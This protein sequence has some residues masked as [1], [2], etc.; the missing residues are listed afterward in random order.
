MSFFFATYTDVIPWLDQRDDHDGIHLAMDLG[1][2]VELGGVADALAV[3]DGIVGV[4]EIFAATPLSWCVRRQTRR[5][6]F[7]TTG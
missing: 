4:E 1:F 6:H 7:P 5:N 2:E 3:K